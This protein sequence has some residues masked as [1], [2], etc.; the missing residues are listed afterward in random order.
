MSTRIV[1]LLCFLLPH[2][3]SAAP[4]YLLA[5]IVTSDEDLL[6]ARVM[7]QSAAQKAELPANFER[8]VFATNAVSHAWARAH[9]EHDGMHYEVLDPPKLREGPAPHLDLFRQ[10]FDTV[11]YISPRVMVKAALG[12]L[13]TCR[14]FCA[15]FHTP[16]SFSTDLMAF[17]P[18]ASDH[19]ALK[20]RA[21]ALRKGQDMSC[22]GGNRPDWLSEEGCIINA[23]FG[24]EL[25]SAPLLRSAGQP[26]PD[27]ARGGLRRLPTGW[28]VAHFFYYV[29]MRWEIPERPCGTIRTVDFSAPGALRPWYWWNFA[30]FE[31]SWEWRRYRKEL[32]SPAGTFDPDTAV[33]LRCVSFFAIAVAVVYFSG[34]RR[35]PDRHP[36]RRSKKIS[37]ADLLLRVVAVGMGANLLSWVV[38]F[39]FTPARLAPVF[40]A[41][42]CWMYR[43]GVLGW[44]WVVLGK[45]IATEQN[46]QIH[47]VVLRR[48]MVRRATIRTMVWCCLDTVAGFVI[49]AVAGA[50]P[51]ATIFNRFFWFLG[52]AFVYIGV[53]IAIIVRLMEVWCVQKWDMND[54]KSSDTVGA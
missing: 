44:I 54:K 15:A 5:T 22:A 16:C 49:V 32:R 19:S 9:V 18:N 47:A 11:L 37:E 23:H 2:L 42:L 29:R 45:R 43:L 53:A 1:I 39:K 50:I 35:A 14:R 8:I 27:A 12:E 13:L 28:K 34:L 3:I 41:E 30:M 33:F 38:A 4:K 20:A 48:R 52:A 36:P 24:K 46:R 6:P 40:A 51:T 26:E 25:M 7:F 31:L 17:S 10:D 21:D